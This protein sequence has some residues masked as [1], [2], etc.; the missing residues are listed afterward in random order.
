MFILHYKTATYCKSERKSKLQMLFS[1]NHDF[2]FTD[3][4]LKNDADLLCCPLLKPHIIGVPSEPGEVIEKLSVTQSPKEEPGKNSM[5][6]M[7][8]NELCL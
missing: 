8:T 7:V 6:N 5:F 4:F 2:L 1:R 3:L